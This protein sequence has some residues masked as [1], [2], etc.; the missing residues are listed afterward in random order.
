MKKTLVLFLALILF[1]CS[2]ISVSADNDTYVYVS[3]ANGELKISYEKISVRD[4]DMDGE[5]TIK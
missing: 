1:I 4:I 3:I 2:A 5:I